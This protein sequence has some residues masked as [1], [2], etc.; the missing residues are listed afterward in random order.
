M[1][2][3][4]STAISGPHDLT[5]DAARSGRAE[6]A[7]LTRTARALVRLA[8]AH[9]RLEHVPTLGQ[10]RAMAYFDG[11]EPCSY[12]L[13]RRVN[14]VPEP[15]EF[16][17][18]RELG[19]HALAFTCRDPYGRAMELVTMRDGGGFDLLGGF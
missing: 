6:S 3:N 8:R 15:M 5:D 7:S 2:E 10:V 9:R 16:G 12:L 11:R 17:Y 14:F 1:T 19:H 18:E 4:R 13:D